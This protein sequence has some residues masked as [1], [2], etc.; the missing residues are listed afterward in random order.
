[1]QMCPEMNFD[2]HIIQKLTSKW[3]L[4]VKYK[5]SGRKQDNL[6]DLGLGKGFADSKSTIHERKKEIMINCTSS[7]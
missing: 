7:N 1:M 5:T 4:N 2:L 3:I 6:H